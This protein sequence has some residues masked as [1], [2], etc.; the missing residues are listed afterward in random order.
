MKKLLVVISFLFLFLVAHAT[1]KETVVDYLETEMPSPRN[2]GIGCLWD[3]SNSTLTDKY[4]ITY[5][6]DQDSL[7]Y[8]ITHKDVNK[9]VLDGNRLLWAGYEN[10]QSNM[11][12]SIAPSVMS[13]PLTFGEKTETEYLLTG[14]YSNSFF[15]VEVGTVVSIADAHGDLVLPG[16]DTITNLLRVKETKL[17]HTAISTEEIKLPLDTVTDTI[18]LQETITYRWFSLSSLIP[19]AIYTESNVYVKGEIV[20]KEESGFLMD[21]DEVKFSMKNHT[22]T[23]DSKKYFQQGLASHSINNINIGNL[24]ITIQG[25]EL[26]AK[27][28]ITSHTEKSAKTTVSIVGLQG[29]IYYQ[30]TYKV[31]TGQPHKVRLDTSPLQPGDYMIV[32]SIDGNES[33]TEKRLLKIR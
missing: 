7:F 15:Q 22:E 1:V 9:Y 18:P 14:K 26:E 5:L 23:A 32:V 3:F 28:N 2:S 21:S 6:S 33:S 17:F 29:Y 11:N 20:L 27:Y 4:K 8:V 16:G 10:R 24:A 25:K 19:V 12:S 13:L 30:E 31:S